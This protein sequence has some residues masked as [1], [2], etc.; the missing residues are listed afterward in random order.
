M[1]LNTKILFSSLIAGECF[2][3]DCNGIMQGTAF[4]YVFTFNIIELG[5]V[6]E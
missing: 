4:L 1:S 6:Q 5:S 2:H 3:V